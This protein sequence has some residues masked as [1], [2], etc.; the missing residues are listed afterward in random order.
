MPCQHKFKTVNTVSRRAYKSGSTK[1]RSEFKAADSFGIKIL[2]ARRQQCLK[3]KKK[4]TTVEISKMQLDTIF[5]KL[6]SKLKMEPDGTALS[7]V[8]KKVRKYLIKISKGKSN[9]R[10]K[11]KAMY[12][13]V[14][15]SVYPSRKFGRGN[16][17]EVVEWIVNISNFDMKHGRPPLNSLVVRG[18]TGMPGNSWNGWKEAFNA[19]FNNAEEAQQACWNFKWQ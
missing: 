11:N 6:S 14:W 19:P 7:D 17:N 10:H 5:P 9:P 16:T 12:K 4:R 18:D 3:C 8:E 2:V 13:E 15:N 1:F